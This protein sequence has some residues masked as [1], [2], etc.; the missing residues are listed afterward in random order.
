MKRKGF[1]LVELLGVLT[2]IGIIAIIALPTVDAILKR[3]RNKTFENTKNT[4]ITSARSWL[5]DYKYLLTDNG[6]VIILTLGDLKELGYIDFDIK[7][8]TT[9]ICLSN[10]NKVTITRIKDDNNNR[11]DIVLDE[12]L[13]DGTEEDCETAVKG[14]HIYLTASPVEIALGSSATTVTAQLKANMTAISKDG[15]DITG[16][17]TCASLNTTKPGNKTVKCSVTNAGVTKE[18]NVKVKVIDKTPPVIV[19]AEDK[20]YPKTT[21]NINLMTGISATDNSG[22]TITV[23]LVENNLKKNASGGYDPGI[24]Y[25]IYSATDSS[26]NTATIQI[27]ITITQ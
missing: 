13:V 18:M 6:D 10:S 8:P 19:G 25:A 5:T 3:S 27:K 20:T 1:T 16:S 2:L 9:E 11:Y 23:K 21:T 17:V 15:T 24:F 26:G 12:K 7:N 4:I 22:E 14:P